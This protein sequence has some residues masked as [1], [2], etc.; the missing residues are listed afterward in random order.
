[1]MLVQVFGPLHL[2]CHN[3]HFPRDGEAPSGTRQKI[4]SLGVAMWTRESLVSLIYFISLHF[5]VGGSRE[6][7]FGICSCLPFSAVSTSGLT[8]KN[9]GLKSDRASLSISCFALIS[10]PHHVPN[11]ET[12]RSIYRNNSRPYSAPERPLFQVNRMVGIFSCWLY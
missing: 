8:S 1:M 5:D 12:S 4:G 7:P 10:S 3:L 11:G 6:R 2:D 9:L